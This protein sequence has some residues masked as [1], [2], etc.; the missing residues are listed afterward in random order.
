[1]ARPPDTDLPLGKGGEHGNP[2]QRDVLV[3][4]TKVARTYPEKVA[5]KIA[6]VA[7][8]PFT[9]LLD[10]ADHD[11]PGQG[12]PAQDRDIIQETFKDLGGA[13]D[14]EFPTPGCPDL[15]TI[16]YVWRQMKRTVPDLH[17]FARAT[18]YLPAFRP[19]G[20][21]GAPHP[22]RYPPLLMPTG[23]LPRKITIHMT[24]SL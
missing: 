7:P 9:F 22:A 8:L 12:A 19:A 13:M 2:G 20:S 18:D 16:V 10:E 15:N 21:P 4:R 23:G 1:M 17:I 24:G 3:W 5:S 14:L 6:S 11:D